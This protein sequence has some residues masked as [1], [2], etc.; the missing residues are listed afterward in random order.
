MPC[1]KRICAFCF[2]LSCFLFSYPAFASTTYH[3]YSWVFDEDDSYQVVFESPLGWERIDQDH[4]IYD[5]QITDKEKKKLVSLYIDKTD[6]QITEKVLQDL[7]TEAYEYL[8]GK[9]SSCNH[10][11][12]ASNNECWHLFDLIEDDQSMPV[13][14]LV[15]N[16]QSYVFVMIIEGHDSIDPIVDFA[17]ELAEL[18]FLTEQEKT[19]Q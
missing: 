1:L 11:V 10:Y 15:Y 8:F 7:E 9:K 14:V 12:K 3:T 16:I 19:K 6:E 2:F 4:E 17:M 13:G 5:L 18:T